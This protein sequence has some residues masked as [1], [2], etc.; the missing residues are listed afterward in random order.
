MKAVDFPVTRRSAE[1]ADALI[2]ETLRDPGAVE[3]DAYL[4][5]S[6]HPSDG[7]HGLKRPDGTATAIV[8]V[9]HLHDPGTGEMLAPRSN[10]TLHRPRVENTV[11][12]R[13]RPQFSKR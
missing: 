10:G 1:L 3:V 4:M 7:L 2:E 9:L 6:G 11:L 5:L 8:C 12:A 13:K